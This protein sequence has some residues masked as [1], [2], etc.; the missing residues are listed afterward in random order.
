MTCFLLA[1]SFR[2]L[3][4]KKTLSCAILLKKKKKKKKSIFADLIRPVGGSS[5]PSKPHSYAPVVY[6]QRCLHGDTDMLKVHA[7]KFGLQRRI[8]ACR[9]A[10]PRTLARC[11]CMRKPLHCDCTAVHLPWVFTLLKV[12]ASIHVHVHEL[13]SAE[14]RCMVK[15]CAPCVGQRRVYMYIT[16]MTRTR[17]NFTSLVCTASLLSVVC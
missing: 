5:E 7:M 10:A 13:Y 8:S 16:K 12:Q 4:P 11:R 17:A 9:T 1:A 14:Y 3:Q 2:P 6:M 15:V